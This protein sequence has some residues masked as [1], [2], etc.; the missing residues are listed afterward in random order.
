MSGKNWMDKQTDRRPEAIALPASLMRSL[1]IV[2]TEN[3]N[4]S[5]DDMDVSLEDSANKAWATPSLVALA[6]RD[7][8]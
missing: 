2:I 5:V 4:F 7:E 3:C 8:S 6:L 1:N